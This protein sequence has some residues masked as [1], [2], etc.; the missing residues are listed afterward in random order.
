MEPV[1]GAA[2]FGGFGGFFSTPIGGLAIATSGG[3]YIGKGT[4]ASEGSR[5]NPPGTASRNKITTANRCLHAVG[6]TA[7]P[8]APASRRHESG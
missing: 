7:S 2:T 3:G 6:G 8:R 1:L 4:K 5:G